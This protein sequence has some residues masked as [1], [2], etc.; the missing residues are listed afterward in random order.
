MLTTFDT[1]TLEEKAALTD[2][3]IE[4]YARLNL[5]LQKVAIVPEPKPLPKVSIKTNPNKIV[6]DLGNI[7]ITEEIRKALVALLVNNPKVTKYNYKNL[8]TQVPGMG[9]VAIPSDQLGYV[10]V[11]S[12]LVVEKEQ[13]DLLK[14]NFSDREYNTFVEQKQEYDKYFSKFKQEVA[15]IHQHCNEIRYYQQMFDQLVD[16]FITKYFNLIHKK[17]DDFLDSFDIAKTYF[18][19]AYSNHELLENVET[20]KVFFEAVAKKLN[21]VNAHQILDRVFIYKDETK[22]TSGDDNTPI[23]HIGVDDLPI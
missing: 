4:D 21:F 14:G 19:S 10:N 8:E 11:S 1:L 5:M 2:E 17:D 6:V 13:V 23:Q 12:T 16:T 7:V 22:D 18:M 15:T 3:Q 20:I 9:Y